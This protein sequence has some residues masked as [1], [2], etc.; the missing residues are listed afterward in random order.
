[1]KAI[2]LTIL[3]PGGRCESFHVEAKDAGVLTVSTDKFSV[4]IQVCGRGD[5]IHVAT[6][7]W[8][9]CNREPAFASVVLSTV[10]ETEVTC[11]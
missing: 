7:C 5:L 3:R 6:S 11:E 8:G 2:G 9:R 4:D 1:M 10:P